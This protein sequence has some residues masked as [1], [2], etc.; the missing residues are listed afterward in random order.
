[1]GRYEP[2]V[3]TDQQGKAYN[4]K[5]FVPNKLPLNP[6]IQ[7]DKKLT[8]LISDTA[9]KIG[10][11]DSIIDTLPNKNNI[12]SQYSLKEA[13]LSSQIE[14]TQSSYQDAM[15]YELL[16][17]DVLDY[18]KAMNVNL[19]DLLETISYMAALETSMKM[20]KKL[21]ISLRIINKAHEIL[22][23]Y[24]RRGTN[25][26]PGKFRSFPNYIAGAGES[27]AEASYI[28][29]PANYVVELISNLEKYINNRLDD[30]N[31]FIKIA[32]THA[33]FEMIHPYYDGNGRIGR[34]LITLMLYENKLIREPIIY[35]SLY[36]KKNRDLYYESLRNIS[37]KGDWQSWITFFLNG[38]VYAAENAISTAERLKKIF[39]EDKKKIEKKIQTSG[40]IVMVFESFQKNPLQRI[41][42][43]KSEYNL[44]NPTI[45]KHLEK[46]EELGII[47]KSK[48]SFY[49]KTIIYTYDRYINA[50]GLE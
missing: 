9:Y 29:P 6:D 41:K 11:L 46:L 14:G 34:L 47:K 19:V 44:S 20:L 28:S 37:L 7:I 5:A 27:P 43:I 8:N 10:Q 23:K 50:I 26:A 39:D 3:I 31:V 35:P 36:F 13:V 32:I 30:E 40:N 48:R 12:I 16:K 45:G 1:M 22:L 21:P 24:G 42:D 33:Q 18:E 38:L 15:L 49:R 17:D 4:C 25:K 2:V